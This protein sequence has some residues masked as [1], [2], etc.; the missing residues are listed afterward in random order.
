M[1]FEKRGPMI[2]QTNGG[3]PESRMAGA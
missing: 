1:A 3:P 2:P